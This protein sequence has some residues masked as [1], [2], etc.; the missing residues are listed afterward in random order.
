MTGIKTKLLGS[1]DL[2]YYVLLS[3]AITVVTVG[4]VVFHLLEKWSWIDSLYFTII[5]LATIG[6][7]DL[8]PTTPVGKLV[9][10]IFVIVGVGIFLGFLNKMMERRVEQ[11]ERRLEARRSKKK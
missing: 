3:F 4:T 9:T 11:R 8:V 2:G 10:V 7:G 1:K 6:Y 5:T